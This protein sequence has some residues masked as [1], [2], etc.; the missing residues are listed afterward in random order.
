MERSTWADNSPSVEI[1]KAFTLAISGNGHR[2][3]EGTIGSEWFSPAMGI[4][5]AWR[6]RQ[7]STTD[8]NCCKLT[9]LYYHETMTIL[10]FV[11]FSADIFLS[12][13]L[14]LT[15][16]IHARSPAANIG[17]EDG[18]VVVEIE[19]REAAC[20]TNEQALSLISSRKQMLTMTIERLV[21]FH[22]CLSLIAKLSCFHGT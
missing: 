18:D 7:Q 17:L 14:S 21:G 22:N 8:R 16:Q 5:F 11:A 10:C 13:T 6:K 9:E 19:S 2:C 3:I 20:L 15:L 4:Y 12:L 1:Y